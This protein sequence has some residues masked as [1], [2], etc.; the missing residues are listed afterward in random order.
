MLFSQ[1]D[2]YAAI[3]ALALRAMQETKAGGPRTI[4]EWEFAHSQDNDTWR[5]LDEYR[6]SIFHK[7]KES[8]WLLTAEK[9]LATD[10][11]GTRSGII[12]KITTRQTLTPWETK[13]A[14][15]IISAEMSKDL[16][17]SPEADARRHTLYEFVIGLRQTRAA[18]ARSL[19]AFRD[20]HKTP[21]ERFRAFMGETLFTPSPAAERAA[22]KLDTEA[23]KEERIA[24]LESRQKIL[25]ELSEK[26]Q[27]QADEIRALEKQLREARETATQEDVLKKD[28]D[29]R[30]ERVQK[31]LRELGVR[32]EDLMGGTVEVRLLGAK[33]IGEVAQGF[34]QQEREI[35]NL[36]QAKKGGDIAEIAKRM[37]VS[38][39]TVRDVMQRYQDALKADLI[40][41]FKLKAMGIKNLLVAKIEQAAL[42]SPADPDERSDFE[43]EEMA[44]KAMEMMGFIPVEEYDARIVRVIK[45]GRSKA[46]RTPKVSAKTPVEMSEW[47]APTGE[48]AMTPGGKLDVWKHEKPWAGAPKGE[49]KPFDT[50]RNKKGMTWK[51]PTGEG[52]TTAGGKLDL[53]EGAWTEAPTGEGKTTDNGKLDLGEG[54]YQFET[55]RWDIDDAGK[56]LQAMRLVQSAAHGST[57]WDYASEIVIANLLSAPATAITNMTGYLYGA[58]RYT[59]RR[60]I[61]AAFNFEKSS[62][63][64]TFGEFKPMFAALSSRMGTAFSNAIRAW[65]TETPV[66]EALRRH[67]QQSLGMSFDEPIGKIPGK[68]GRVV[69]TPMRLLLATDEFAKTLFAHTHA[70]TIAHRMGR[71]QGLEG[72]ALA[73]WI[74]GQMG[75]ATSAIW[76]VALQEARHVTFQDKLRTFGEMDSQEIGALNKVMHTPEAFLAHLTKYKNDAGP[77]AGFIHNATAFMLRATFPFIK[78]PY[79][80]LYIGLKESFLGGIWEAGR[81]KGGLGTREKYKNLDGTVGYGKRDTAGA[82]NARAAIVTSALITSLLW[83]FGEGDDDDNDKWLLFTGTTPQKDEKA[84][85][86]REL[87]N[88][89]IP[90][91]S[92]RIRIAGQEYTF[93]YSRLD[94]FSTWIATTVDTLSSVKQAEKG[95]SMWQAASRSLNSIFGQVIEKASLRG[96]S[97]VADLVLGGKAPDAQGVI[98]TGAAWV[99]PNL[100]RN[101][102]RNS[103]PMVRDK[104]SFADD[105]AARIKYAIS[106]TAENAPAA[107]RDL[108]GKPMEQRGNFI[109]RA[110][111]PGQ[112]RAQDAFAR[113]DKTLQNWNTQNPA[114]PFAPTTPDFKAQL[115]HYKEKFRATPAQIDRFLKTRGEYI[116][117]QMRAKGLSGLR[118]P[119]AA[120][121]DELEKIAGESSAHARKMVFGK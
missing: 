78:T 66:T 15:K 33:V 62:D 32:I 81:H 84:Q 55:S 74:N 52:K 76:D 100:Y 102:A 19:A 96:F 11:A 95:K 3:D 68:F 18:T 44:L 64:A 36:S 45:P 69:R 46:E 63:A 90:E 71:A 85:G 30:Y 104:D 67:S 109:T 70:A 25:K 13:A 24:T 51:A 75:D 88:R 79:N 29:E 34:T 6:K 48:G 43:A 2:P 99:V 60:A 57:Y 65:D 28:Q 5:G 10:Y 58:Y 4:G 106:P 20:P 26:S 53:G 54:A 107:K 103:D 93:G 50:L 35:V 121:I 98:D 41:K 94:P 27:K 119:T 7:E 116:A 61:E 115:A 56:R 80:L 42:L 39:E 92:V 40:K 110:F 14:E 112:P 37:D 118:K 31:R 91:Q 117:Q 49:G 12:A 23:Q 1:A 47:S 86:L 17:G 101:L 59:F 83:A 9:M 21:E 89:T 77:D 108:Y 114:A 87:R 22:A 8:D 72:S 105:T 73:G 82:I 38:A 97:R 120:Q 16:H 111:I 113:E